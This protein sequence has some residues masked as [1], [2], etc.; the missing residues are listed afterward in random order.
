MRRSL[1]LFLFLSVS[2]FFLIGAS[3]FRIVMIA[4]PRRRQH[5]SALLTLLWAKTTLAVMEMS[6]TV[7]GAEHI[8]GRGM[9]ITSNHQ[10]YLD[11]IIL[12]SVVPSLFVAK[13]EVRTWPLLGWLATLGGTLYID[14]NAFRGAVA[15]MENIFRALREHVNVVIFPEGTSTNG[16][17]IVL[18][19]PALFRSALTAK[20]SVL[21][22]TI[23]YRSVNGE[24]ADSI[25]RDL[26]CWYGAMTF[27]KHFWSLLS[28]R[29]M[30]VSVTIHPA[31]PFTPLME[32]DRLCEHSYHAVSAG[33][34]PF[35]PSNPEIVNTVSR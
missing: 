3:L 13:K 20:R 7:N 35:S 27:S 24:Q 33:F 5:F 14:R 26:F 30:K 23:N 32:P 15:A 6:V 11:I 4:A 31:I 12:A 19:K 34:E 8:T 9:L 17:Q 10:S 18:F 16:E 28:A 29:S 25:N 21:P 1:K 22:V 2:L